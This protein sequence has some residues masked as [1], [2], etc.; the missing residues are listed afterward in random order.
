MNKQKKILLLGAIKRAWS[1]VFNGTSATINAGTEAS[2]DDLHANLMTV[3][4]HVKISPSASAAGYIISKRGGGNTGWF[5]GWD[6]NNTLRAFLFCATTS[7][8]FTDIVIPALDTW[9]HVAFTYDN[10]TERKSKMYID[11]VLKATST[12]AVGDIASDAA[13]TMFIGSLLGS[14][15]WLKGSV[16]WV[17]VSNNLRYT[18]AFAPPSRFS[19]PTVDA[20]TVRLFKMD[21]GTGTTIIDYSANAQNATLANG[22][23][24]KK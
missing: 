4:A 1:V 24:T 20:N 8:Q 17:R 3:E 18:T 5:I 2:I 9:F 11:G 22:T 15:I 19:Y 10:I 14:S 6:T 16:G 23:W 7:P 21:E 13:E 12:G